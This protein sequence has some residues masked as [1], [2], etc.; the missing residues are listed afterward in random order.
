MAIRSL[1]R[2]DPLRMMQRW[3]P[4][5]ELREMQ[6]DMDRLFARFGKDV[7]ISA[8]GFGEWIPSVESY[9]KGN[10]LIFKFELPGLDPK[11][12]NVTVDESAHQLIVSG[13]R[14]SEKETKEEDY[15]NRELVYGTFERRFILPE[16]VKSDQVKAKFTNGILEVSVPAAELRKAKKIEIETPKMIEVEKKTEAKKAA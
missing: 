13:E 12:V 6:R 4:F 2:W 10:D 16:G 11:E 7:S 15:I 14:K 1:T 3:D 8:P 9:R 5:S